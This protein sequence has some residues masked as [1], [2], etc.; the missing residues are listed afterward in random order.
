[1]SVLI[2]LN[3]NGVQLLPYDDGYYRPT[4]GTAFVR[5]SYNR[6]Y[7]RPTY[8]RPHQGRHQYPG[9]RYPDYSNTQ[10]RYRNYEDS[11]GNRY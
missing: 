3:I 9:G 5:P 4:L 11:Y 7:D 2:V 6:P 8:D 10:T 1:M